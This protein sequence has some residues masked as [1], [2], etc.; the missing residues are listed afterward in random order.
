[1]INLFDIGSETASAPSYYWMSK[2]EI[3]KTNTRMIVAFRYEICFAFPKKGR[4]QEF[5][6]ILIFYLRNILLI[7]VNR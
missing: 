6:A 5:N 7:N 1:M 3:K 2:N 4:R